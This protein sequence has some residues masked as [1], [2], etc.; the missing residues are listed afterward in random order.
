MYV[1]MHSVYV[2]LES[3]KLFTV[4]ITCVCGHVKLYH[5]HPLLG[6]N[7]PLHSAHHP[8]HYMT[9]AVVTHVHCI[10]HGI[11]M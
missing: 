11:I 8:L 10:F 5:I 7:K 2:E 1:G 9:R 4:Q 3:M 6:V